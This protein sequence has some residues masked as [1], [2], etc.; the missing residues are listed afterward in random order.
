MLHSRHAS[1][2]DREI[3]RRLFLGDALVSGE[4]KTGLEVKAFY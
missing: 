1:I 2:T 3:S 4:D